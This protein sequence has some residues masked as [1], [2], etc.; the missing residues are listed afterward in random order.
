MVWPVRYKGV[1]IHGPITV[2]VYLYSLVGC[3]GERRHGLM[4]KGIAQPHKTLEVEA[5]ATR[6]VTFRVHVLHPDGSCFIV[7]KLPGH[8]G[9][10]S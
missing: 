9:T 1:E 6:L 7:V 4:A 2:A 5:R 8:E 3:Q 10:G